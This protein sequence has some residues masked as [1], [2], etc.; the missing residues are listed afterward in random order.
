M[1]REISEFSNLIDEQFDFEG[2]SN[3]FIAFVLSFFN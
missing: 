3:R 2:P 1:S